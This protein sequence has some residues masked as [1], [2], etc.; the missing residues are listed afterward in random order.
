MKY[1]NLYACGRCTV[2][3]K[4]DFDRSRI[5]N[6]LYYVN[7]GCAVIH[8]G[9]DE[10]RLTNGNF[11]I[12]PQCKSFQPIDSKDFDHTYFDFYH[13]QILRHDTLL[14]FDKTEMNG[15][16][17][18]E[19]INSLPVGDRGDE[20]HD[21]I[22]HLLCGYLTILHTK[23]PFPYISN[24]YVT[25]AID[26]VH[27]EYATITTKLLACKINL[28]ESYFIRLFSTVMDMTP[29][30]Y[31]RACRIAHGRQLLQSGLSVAE[32][33]EQCGYKSPT[34][35]YNATVAELHCAPSALK[36]ET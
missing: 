5:L 12:I 35:F 25:A 22:E 24:A 32:A 2:N 20:L 16:C 11:Y 23:Q 9:T 14:A 1:I 31:I 36:R 15:V 10:Y 29:A 17:F 34:A 13:S 33:A 6:R 18:F 27:R 30:K 21:A 28:D 4:W 3:G 26:I 8:N 19:Y 7:S